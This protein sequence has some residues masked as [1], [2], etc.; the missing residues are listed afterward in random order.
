MRCDVPAPPS[1][2]TAQELWKLFK[3]GKLG[4]NVL[5][6]P[7]NNL[8]NYKELVRS[9]KFCLAP[10]GHGWG[11]RLGQYMVMGCVPVLV[12]DGV[13][14]PYQDLLPYD[15]FSV[16]I[17]K[18]RLPHIAEVLASISDDEY[19]ALRAGVAKHWPAFVWHPSWGGQAYNLTMQSLEQRAHNFLGGLFR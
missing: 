11:N 5:I 16:R 12:Q 7:S 9:S 17:P 14:Q 13:Y 18:A 1:L 10:W 8:P 3:A 15:E 6:S 19:R 4:S 2:A